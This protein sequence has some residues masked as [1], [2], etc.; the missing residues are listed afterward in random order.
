MVKERDVGDSEYWD[1]VHLANISAGVP[2]T[3]V[4]V[5]DVSHTYGLLSV[6]DEPAIKRL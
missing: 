2:A 5:H 4:C 6:N 1:K 3:P